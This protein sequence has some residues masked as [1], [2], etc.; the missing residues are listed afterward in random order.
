MHVCL[1]YVCLC[2][3]CMPGDMEATRGCW[4]PWEWSYMS[5]H[6]NAG[7]HTWNPL[8]ERLMPFIKTNIF[9]TE[10]LVSNYIESL[11][12]NLEKN[13]FCFFF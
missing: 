7:N 11:K 8:E 6:I 13:V 4:I 5:R 2:A 10:L 3:M 12:I 9:L 1:L